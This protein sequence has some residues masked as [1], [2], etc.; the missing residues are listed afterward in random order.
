MESNDSQKDQA[1]I[2]QGQSISL[3]S[4]LFYIYLGNL[5]AGLN[6]SSCFTIL[7]RTYSG[8]GTYT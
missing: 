4:Y 7:I 1:G 5:R 6:F 3:L 2:K 8:I